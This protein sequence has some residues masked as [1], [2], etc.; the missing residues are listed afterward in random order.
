MSAKA[1]T[2]RMLYVTQADDYWSDSIYVTKDG[3]ICIKVGGHAITR[4][5]QEWHKIAL[6]AVARE[7]THTTGPEQGT[8]RSPHGP[9]RPTKPRQS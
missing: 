8:D 3:G 4:T 1:N 5:L 6:D 9:S 2:D 7:P